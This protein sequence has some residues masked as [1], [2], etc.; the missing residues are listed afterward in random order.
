MSW[1]GTLANW[2]RTLFCPTK[3]LKLEYLKKSK[4]GRQFVSEI[5]TN[6]KD[7]ISIPGHLII[8]IEWG[9]FTMTSVVLE[10]KV[11][12]RIRI[13]GGKNP[14]RNGFVD[15]K[16]SRSYRV[17]EIYFST[18][19]ELPIF[20]DDECIC[21]WSPQRHNTVV[22]EQ[23]TNQFFAEFRVLKWYYD[24]KIISFFSSDFESVFA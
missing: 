17:A 4:H 23:W 14:N 18:I 12:W 1:S 5:F 15:G 20:I 3:M 6:L 22:L 16:L 19:F 2:L 7:I 9:I 10:P 13:E 24:R 21:E 11:F 8:L